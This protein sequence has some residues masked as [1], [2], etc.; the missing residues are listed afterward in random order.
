MLTSY[1]EAGY[2]YLAL[3][4]PEEERVLGLLSSVCRSI[5]RPLVPI[6]LTSTRRSDPEATPLSCLEAVAGQQSPAVFA[7][8]DFHPWISDPVVV[9]SL[10]DMRLRL[11]SR[12]QTVVFVS[13][14]LDVP[15]DLATDV[16]MIDVPLPAQEDLRLLL[17]AEARQGGLELPEEVSHRAVRAVQGLTAASARRAFR[18]ACLE[19]S[20]LLDGDVTTL[21][22]EKRRVL[23]RT[24]VLEF[25]DTPP[26]LDDVGGLDNLKFWLGDREAAF[27]PQAR[28][29][30]LPTPKGL[31]LVGVQGCGKSLTAKAVARLWNLPLTRLDFGSLF[32][33]G[34]P[35]GNLRRVLRLAEALAPVVLWIDEID[36]AFQP[37]SGA[38]GPSEAQQRLLAGFI[39]WLQEKQSQTFVVATANTVDRLPPELMRKGRFDEIFFVDLPNSEERRQI[40][41]IHLTAHGRE[42]GDFDTEA[43]AQVCEHFS[44]AELEQVVVDGLFRAFRNSRA[45]DIE[46]LRIAATSTVPLYRTYEDEIKALREWSLSRARR[47]STDGRLADLWKG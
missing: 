24:D 11:E 32:A 19:P 29:F 4:S 45:L 34:S 47:A 15:Y 39:T 44:G 21:V 2:P 31:L 26:S 17:D 40:L 27:S 41:D 43:I 22:R 8:I 14:Q 42:A 38:A 46:D 1:L 37:G 12:N 18:R 5:S 7:L 13:P 33:G 23:R 30:G 10:R 6:S 36:K 9:R 3:L 16:V 35:D 28:Q 20:A 25:V